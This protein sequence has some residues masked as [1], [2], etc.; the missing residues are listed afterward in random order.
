MEL[1]SICTIYLP[2]I[3]F[4]GRLTCVPT[5]PSISVVDVQFWKGVDWTGPGPGTDRVPSLRAF[6]TLDLLAV[7]SLTAA[8]ILRRMSWT[9]CSVLGWHSIAAAA[10]SELDDDG[11]SVSV[12]CA[13]A[14]YLCESSFSVAHCSK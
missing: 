11:V 13:T 1:C 7:R 10:S 2:S 14:Q 5:L 3:F 6:Q 4:V 12:S 8:G 9:W